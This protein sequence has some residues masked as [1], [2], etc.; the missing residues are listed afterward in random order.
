MLKQYNDQVRIR[1]GSIKPFHF[2]NNADFL[3]L[4]YNVMST[5]NQSDYLVFELC[6]CKKYEGP[7]I[8]ENKPVKRLKTVSKDDRIKLYSSVFLFPRSFAKQFVEIS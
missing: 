4:C 2:Q 8:F 6:C 5:L 1:D 3:V 7:F